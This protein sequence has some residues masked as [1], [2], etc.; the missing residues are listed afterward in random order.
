MPHVVSKKKTEKK[1]EAAFFSPANHRWK[2]ELNLYH[3]PAG[4][5]NVQEQHLHTPSILGH[6]CCHFLLYLLLGLVPPFFLEGNHWRQT[7]MRVLT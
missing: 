7:L 2:A 5:I 4:F 1:L 6:Y 3:V